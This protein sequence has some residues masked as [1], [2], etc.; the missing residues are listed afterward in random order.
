MSDSIKKYEE[1]VADGKITAGSFTPS[2]VFEIPQDLVN[3]IVI[4]SREYPLMTPR[5][6]YTMAVDEMKSKNTSR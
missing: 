5:A 1:L 4:Y 6:I 3:N 2:R